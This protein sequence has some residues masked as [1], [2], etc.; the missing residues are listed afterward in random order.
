M[1]TTSD[2]VQQ[3]PAYVDP[4]VLEAEER[5]WTPTRIIVWVGVALLGA[6]GWGAIA[7]GRGEPINAVWL[8]FAA[9]GTY[10]IAYRFYAKYI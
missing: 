9:V 1:S 7:L 8:V 10:L 4:D 3:P 6:V 5:K 2:E